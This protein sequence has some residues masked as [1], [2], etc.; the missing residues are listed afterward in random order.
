MFDSI[1]PEKQWMDSE[2][3]PIMDAT[4]EDYKCPT[5]VP[6]ERIIIVGPGASEETGVHPELPLRTHYFGVMGANTEKE[7]SIPNFCDAPATTTSRYTMELEPGGGRRANCYANSKG[8]MANNGLIIRRH[9]TGL[10][11]PLP[12]VRMG[13]CSDG[14]SK[15]VMVGESAFGDPNSP[16]RA[17]QIGVTG[18]YAYSVKNV[19]FAINSGCRGPA[20]CANPE[21]NNIGFG[22]E[23]PG[24]ACHFVMGD[25]SVHFMS[26]NIDLLVLF[27]LASRA[28]DDLVTDDVFN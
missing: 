24:G 3:D 13:R 14:L 9:V 20:P 18:E 4:V 21:R 22:S 8:G 11:E 1:Y 19:A 17:W 26:E 12:P 27:A 25:G 16:T 6:I 28:A 5:R 23:H 15:T 2:N 7:A 10:L